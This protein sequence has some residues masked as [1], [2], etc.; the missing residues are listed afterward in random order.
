MFVEWDL[1]I[2]CF[3]LSELKVTVTMS[4]EN[5][6][7]MKYSES[8]QGTQMQMSGSLDAMKSSDCNKKSSEIVT[9]NNTSWYE[10]HQLAKAKGKDFLGHHSAPSFQQQLIIMLITCICEE[11]M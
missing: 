5:L 3:S 2:F 4:Q 11:N 9:D 6:G 8:E 10:T 7:Y 1:W